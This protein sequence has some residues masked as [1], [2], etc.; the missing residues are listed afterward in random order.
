MGLRPT[1][2]LWGTAPSDCGWVEGVAPYDLAGRQQ[3]HLRPKSSTLSC[4]REHCPTLRG[5]PGAVGG[6]SRA[7][8]DLFNSRPDRP[9]GPSAQWQ[10]AELLSSTNLFFDGPTR[11]CPLTCT[12]LSQG[13]SHAYFRLERTLQSPLGMATNTL[14][15]RYLQHEA[16]TTT[17]TE[18]RAGILRCA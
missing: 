4:R 7:L 18:G 13:T 8:P 14:K 15:A 17:A 2:H 10:L 3:T 5:T 16:D 6:G 9:Y 11:S 12:R 1:G